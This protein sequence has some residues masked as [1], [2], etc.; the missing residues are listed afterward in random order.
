MNCVYVVL[1][2]SYIWNLKFQISD[3]AE[4]ILIP[5]RIFK[6]HLSVTKLGIMQIKVWKK[7]FENWNEFNIIV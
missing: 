5:R 7:Y 4:C 2:F 3:G 6:E 1:N